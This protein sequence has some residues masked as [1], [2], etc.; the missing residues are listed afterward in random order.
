[1]QE[2]NNRATLMISS[3]ILD[4]SVFLVDANNFALGDT[5]QFGLTAARYSNTPCEIMGINARGCGFS[6]INGVFRPQVYV[7]GCAKGTGLLDGY[8]KHNGGNCLGR[9]IGNQ[10]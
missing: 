1:M 6:E 7:F 8:I 10:E 2:A 9:M 5:L 3:Q 4:A